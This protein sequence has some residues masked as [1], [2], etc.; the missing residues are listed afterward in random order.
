M[1]EILNSESFQSSIDT[2][3]QLSRSFKSISL[4]DNYRNIGNF[5]LYISGVLSGVLE[6]NIPHPFSPINIQLSR[7]GDIWQM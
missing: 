3:C 7:K 5:V 2:M 6:L 4:L 1:L